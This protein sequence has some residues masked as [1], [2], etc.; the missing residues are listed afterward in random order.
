MLCAAGVVQQTR[1][2]TSGQVHQPRRGV[3]IGAPGIR[4]D[5]SSVRFGSAV[6]VTSAINNVA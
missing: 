1:Q 5:V 4:L 3:L 6:V 2:L